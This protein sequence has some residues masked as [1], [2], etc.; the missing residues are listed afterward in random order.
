MDGA[1]APP[2]I[3]FRGISKRFGAF[4]ANRDITLEIEE[5]EIHALVG[6]NGAGKSTLMKILFGQYQPDS[7]SLLL[8]GRPVSF[9]TPRR[10][11]DAGIGMVHQQPSVFPRMTALENIVLGW[12]PRKRGRKPMWFRPGEA[13]DTLERLC[14]SFA[15][16]LPLDMPAR[17]LSF[18]QLRQI[19]ILR[20]LYRGAR[21]IILDE[22]TS[23]LSPPE[24]AGLLRSIQTL[25][26]NGH[27][28]IFI[29]HRLEEVFSVAR[30]ISVLGK[31]VLTATLKTSETCPEEV[32]GL[33]MAELGPLHSS[34]KREGAVSPREAA[35]SGAGVPVLP[36]VGP[37]GP[38]TLQI[39]GL[40]V[41]GR[42]AEYGLE[43][44]SLEVAQGEILG[45]GGIAGNGHRTLARALA[46]VIPVRS[47]EILLNGCSIEGRSVAERLELGLG[48]LPADC[49]G[50]WMLPGM[51]VWENLLPDSKGMRPFTAWGGLL[52]DKIRRWATQEA[53][54][55]EVACGDVDM[56]VEGLSGGNRQKLALGWLFAAHRRVLVL[57]QPAQ[58]L[59]LRAQERL[60]ET[61]RR[62]SGE[63]VAFVI[64]SHDLHQLMLLCGRI[65]VLYKGKIT[66]VADAETATPELLGNWMLGVKAPAS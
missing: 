44:F 51:T 55:Y 26:S 54:Q 43:N 5:G 12:E 57:E 1:A 20:V 28:L 61:V 64:L 9:R 7:G 13:R 65:A 52:K 42:G 23:L 8:R 18:A 63:G 47:G 58:G 2:L 62:L 22:P 33:M 14:R 40:T 46:G 48:W 16:D 39:R 19:E 25:G 36:D 50:E 4:W 24:S 30:R 15:F 35:V 10:A 59:D 56:P 53:A 11:V 31:G 45:I 49:A 17:D 21:I 41:E 37:S 3:A 29:S 34:V 27:T 38:A 60:R 66:G 6:E 32:V